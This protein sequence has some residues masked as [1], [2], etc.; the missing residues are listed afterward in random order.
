MPNGDA[1]NPSGTNRIFGV[2]LGT[3]QS[4]L[5][6]SVGT[7]IAFSTKLAGVVTDLGFAN[8]NGKIKLLAGNNQLSV[9]NIEG[10]GSTSSTVK[11]LNWREV[12]TAD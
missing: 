10:P 8:L 7:Q 12:P 1:C 3:G 5:T 11:K 4:V 2:N 6:D 9:S